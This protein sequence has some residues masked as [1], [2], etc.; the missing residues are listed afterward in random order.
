MTHM[1][2]VKLNRF[3]T[4]LN[5]MRDVAECLLSDIGTSG[6]GTGKNRLVFQVDKSEISD[7]C[8]KY[9]GT[10]EGKYTLHVGGWN[11]KFF[12]TDQD[13]EHILDE[14]VHKVEVEKKQKQLEADK[15]LQKSSNVG[16]VDVFKR[17]VKYI[18]ENSNYTIYL[19]VGDSK[20]KIDFKKP[21]EEWFVGCD[22]N[23]PVELR[24]SGH[25]MR[26]NSVKE[27]LVA[28]W[29]K[30]SGNPDTDNFASL[31]RAIHYWDCK[32]D[33]LVLNSL[34]KLVDNLHEL[35]R[36]DADASVPVVLMQELDKFGIGAQAPEK[37]RKKS[38]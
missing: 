7:T 18:K 31:L 27:F 13:F 32:Y 36:V 3:L 11:G 1:E 34:R 29:E 28:P 6:D 10:W 26:W 37:G 38:K 17:I 21:Y 30:H 8:V 22:E 25:F 24:F 19:G 15:K 35:V 20:K 9:N 23:T 5:A 16:W 4:K 14:V 2:E 33:R 12:V